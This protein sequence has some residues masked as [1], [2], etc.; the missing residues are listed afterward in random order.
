[1]EISKDGQLEEVEIIYLDNISTTGTT[2][3]VKIY[4]ILYRMQLLQS[5]IGTMFLIFRHLLVWRMGA[6]FCQLEWHTEKQ[7]RIGRAWLK[8]KLIHEIC[9]TASNLL[10]EW[11]NMLIVDFMMKKMK[12]FY[13]PLSFSFETF[14]TN[15]FFI[16]LWK[17]IQDLIN[18][19][20][21]YEKYFLFT[22]K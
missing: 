16:K 10:W 12:D 21:I 20:I 3:F 14:S 13:F 5:V 9:L 6:W 2:L 15:T 11:V 19:Y 22:L 17:I 1:M 4:R 18:I 7:Y 8:K